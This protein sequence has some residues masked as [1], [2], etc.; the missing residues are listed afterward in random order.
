MKWTLIIVAFVLI[1]NEATQTKTQEEIDNY[2]FDVIVETDWYQ[3]NYDSL[4]T[5]SN[6]KI[7][8]LYLKQDTINNI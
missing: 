8:E 3:E 5:L 4:S 1:Y 7:Y 6:Q 2:V